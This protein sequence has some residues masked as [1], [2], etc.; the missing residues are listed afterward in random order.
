MKL[1]NMH[2]Q[3]MQNYIE[4]IHIVQYSLKINIFCYYTTII[5]LP[6]GPRGARTQ[7][8]AL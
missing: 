7:C 1:Q 6:A 8:T 5:K 3:K 4:N 2:Y